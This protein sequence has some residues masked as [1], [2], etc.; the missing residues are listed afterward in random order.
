MIFNAILYTLDFAQE[1]IFVEKLK[2]GFRSK[3]KKMVR[4][5]MVFQLKKTPPQLRRVFGGNGE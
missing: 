4:P 3:K 5:S 1:F 2:F